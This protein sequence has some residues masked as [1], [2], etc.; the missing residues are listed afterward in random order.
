MPHN[1]PKGYDD[2]KKFEA[3]QKKLLEQQQLLINKGISKE[4][5]AEYLG[6]YVSGDINDKDLTVGVSKQDKETEKKLKL[7]NEA[8]DMT[9]KHPKYNM[10]QWVA[11]LHN[12]PNAQE[13]TNVFNWYV[14]QY[15]NAILPSNLKD[16]VKAELWSRFQREY[17]K[18]R[19][20]KGW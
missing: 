6:G 10:N 1:V 13:L 5:L 14:N 3:D 4:D 12:A 11:D 9:W 15:N 7:I 20:Q 19:K 18:I 16:E 8:T 17:D 2:R